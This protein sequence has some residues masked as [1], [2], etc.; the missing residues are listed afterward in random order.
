MGFLDSLLFNSARRVALDAARSAVDTI[1]DELSAS[2]QNRM[3]N[4]TPAA[5]E[6][7]TAKTASAGNTE[8]YE[9]LCSAGLE[10]KLDAVLQKEFSQ[11]TFRK[12]VSPAEFGG[13]GEFLPFSYVIY[14]GDTP[15]LILMMVSNNTCASRKYRW[16]K[17]QAQQSG[18]TL[19]NFV[20]AFENRID[21]I[22]NRLHQYL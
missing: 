18:V 7:A 13:T 22:I 4:G 17:E 8:G 9:G 11:Y 20:Y 19:I 5:S 1:S 15:K 16:S 12:E 2:V 10:R 21:Y 6:A 14:Q 3:K